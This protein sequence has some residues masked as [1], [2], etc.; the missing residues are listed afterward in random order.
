MAKRMKETKKGRK[1]KAFGTTVLILLIIL[2]ILVGAIFVF[3]KERLKG[4]EFFSFLTIM[5][6]HGIILI[7]ML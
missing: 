4:L 1:L 2:A 5:V 7:V 3:K 6:K